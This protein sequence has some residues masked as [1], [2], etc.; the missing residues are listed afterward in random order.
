MH[1]QLLMLFF[2]LLAYIPT[3][4]IRERMIGTVKIIT[5]FFFM[6]IVVQLIFLLICF[7]TQ[8]IT[9]YWKLFISVG[10]WPM[11]IAE[12]VIE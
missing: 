1:P 8:Y 6:N 2:V 3:V 9:E 4:C 5:G 11:I 7:I 10:M 12:I